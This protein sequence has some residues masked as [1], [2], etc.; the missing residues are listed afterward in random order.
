MKAGKS[1]G[2]ALKSLLASDPRAETRQVAM[3]DKDGSIAAHTGKHCPGAAGHHQGI[4]YSVQANLMRNSTVWSA[5]AQTFETA[6]GDLAERMLLALEA[7]ED[8]GGDLRGK[9]SAAL[10][11]ASAQ[12]AQGCLLNVRVDDSSQPLQELRRLLDMDRAYNYG[13]RAIDLLQAPVSSER[14]AL[15]QEELSRSIALMPR[16]ACAFEQQ[17]HFAVALLCADQFEA[18]Q[19]LFEELFQLDPLW[20]EM[21]SRYEQSGIFEDAGRFSD[22]AK[23]VMQMFEGR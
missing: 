20:K 3:V 5:M 22:R 2:Q 9:Q 14:L 13:R 11:I 18:A 16:R 6:R 15:A 7:A 12:P 8:T 21:L 19:S 23:R 4:G 17:F 1:A 10:L